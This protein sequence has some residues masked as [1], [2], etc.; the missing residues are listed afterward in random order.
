MNFKK[1][2]LCFLCVLLAS[3]TFAQKLSV[4]GGKFA[5]ENPGCWVEV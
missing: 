3:F 1:I 5:E 4:T 2:T